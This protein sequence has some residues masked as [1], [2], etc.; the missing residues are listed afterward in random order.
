MLGTRVLENRPAA[1]LTFVPRIVSEAFDQW[2]FV[3][4]VAATVRYMRAMSVM[5][6][7]R[8][9][10]ALLGFLAC[11]AL[12]AEEP[13]VVLG[14]NLNGSQ[15]APEARRVTLGSN[16]FVDP[17]NSCNYDSNGN[18]YA[19]VG[20]DNCLSPGTTQWVGV[21]FIAAAT[22]VPKQISV[23]IIVR[24]PRNCPTP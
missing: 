14:G 20:P 2:G 11:G 8:S 24:D 12:M 17:C 4:T 10:A 18:G 9:G 15:N 5:L 13:E 16:L 7:V 6:N 21:P 3:L 19:V 22:G 23:P 1:K